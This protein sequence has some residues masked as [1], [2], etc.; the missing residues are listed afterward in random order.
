MDVK[1]AFD[2]IMNGK[3]VF[4]PVLHPWGTGND[5]LQGDQAKPYASRDLIHTLHPDWP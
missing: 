4:L 5:T 1:G 2:D 3:C